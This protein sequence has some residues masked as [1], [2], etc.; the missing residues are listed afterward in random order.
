RPPARVFERGPTS[1]EVPLVGQEHASCVRD[2]ERS[3]RLEALQVR[4]RLLQRRRCSGAVS[5]ECDAQ[6]GDPSERADTTEARLRA[7]Q[8][9][10]AEVSQREVILAAVPAEFGGAQERCTGSFAEPFPQGF[11]AAR[12]ELLGE[13]CR[14]SDG[15]RT[16]RRGQQRDLRGRALPCG[17]PYTGHLPMLSQTVDQLL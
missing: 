17:H 16:R 13:A 5:V 10:L 3:I 11:V 9:D 12:A 1:L 4:L 14:V 8:G 2:L 7:G 15:E 6:D